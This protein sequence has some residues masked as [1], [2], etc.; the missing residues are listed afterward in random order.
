[1]LRPRLAFSP[2][3]LSLTLSGAALSKSSGRRK[4]GFRRAASGSRG[5]STTYLHQGQR[6][7]WPGQPSLNTDFKGR[8]SPTCQGQKW[9]RVRV[10]SCP[11]RTQQRPPQQPTQASPRSQGATQHMLHVPIAA[12]SEGVHA[13]TEL[14][15][16]LWTQDPSASL[17]TQGLGQGGQRDRQRQLGFQTG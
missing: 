8:A 2:L 16:H 4:G 15:C 10:H 3:S 13:P 14:P 12:S 6:G 1:M 11:P 17:T 9:T 5:G 7:Q